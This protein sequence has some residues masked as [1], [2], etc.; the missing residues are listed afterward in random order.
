[1]EFY[2]GEYGAWGACP[3]DWQWGLVC[4]YGPASGPLLELSPEVMTRGLWQA[5]QAVAPAMF[6]LAE[7]DV[8]YPIRWR[9]AVP[10]MAPGHYRR[11]AAHVH[12]PPVVLA[13][14]WMN[15]ACVEG[16][17]HSGEAAAAA[18]GRA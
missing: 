8:V 9:W 12:R 5:G 11:L 14:D 6:S 13:G 7:A 1:V 4:A 2:S 16:A 17:V 18:F 3:A 10:V 15:Q